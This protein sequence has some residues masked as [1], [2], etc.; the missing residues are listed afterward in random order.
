[1]ETPVLRYTVGLGLS[2]LAQLYSVGGTIFAVEL[3]G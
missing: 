3:K 2:I 1:M